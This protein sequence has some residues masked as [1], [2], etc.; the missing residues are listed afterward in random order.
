MVTVKKHKT[1]RIIILI[2]TSILVL[3]FFNPIHRLNL[4]LL[5]S[6]FVE[7]QNI[8]PMGTNLIW[9]KSYIGGLGSNGNGACNYVIGELRSFA[10]S[11]EKIVEQ[12]Q[13][14]L[15]QDH[16]KG[17]LF[18]DRDNWPLDSILWDWR[19]EFLD[20]NHIEEG[21]YYIVYISKEFP[22]LLDVHCSGY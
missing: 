5:R 3:M 9:R 17:I 10:D 11:R 20:Q 18:M 7:M 22:S 16:N 4:F 12:Y 15:D 6:H 13:K 21:K 2:I 1:I 19:G 8:K 14:V